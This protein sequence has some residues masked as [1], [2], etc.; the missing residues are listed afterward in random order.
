MNNINENLHFLDKDSWPLFESEFEQYEFGRECV[1]KTI[2]F[3]LRTVKGPRE[4]FEQQKHKLTDIRNLFDNDEIH[5][6]GFYDQWSE[7]NDAAKAI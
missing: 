7:F 6:K 2:E 1:R 3:M 4:V 5:S